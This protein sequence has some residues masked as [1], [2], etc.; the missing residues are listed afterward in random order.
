MCSA[1][2]DSKKIRL[3]KNQEASWLLSNLGSKTL[4]RKIPVLA[5]ILV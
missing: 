3:I 4:F 2:C 5:D 1:V